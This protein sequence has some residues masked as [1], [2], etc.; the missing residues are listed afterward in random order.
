MKSSRL[1]RLN[2]GNMEDEKLEDGER[3]NQASSPNLGCGLA[4]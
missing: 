1:P 3:D 2:G 4:K